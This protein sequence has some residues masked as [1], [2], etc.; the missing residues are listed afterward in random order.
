MIRKLEINDF[1]NYLNLMKKFRNINTQISKPEII[2]IYNKIF[3]N[4][5]IYIFLIEDK[6]IGSITILIEQKIIHNFGRAAHIEDLY[7]DENY[8]KKNIGSQLIQAAIDYSQQQKCYKIILD[9]SDTL[10]KFYN[11]NGFIRKESQFVQY[12]K[13]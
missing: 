11:K 7:I 6:I 1:E 12:L 8:R 3:K 9:A 10:T 4:S 13:I 5:I 2:N